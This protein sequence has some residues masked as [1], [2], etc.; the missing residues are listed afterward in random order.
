MFKEILRDEVFGI[1]ESFARQFQLIN[2]IQG[3]DHHLIIIRATGHQ[4]PAL[5]E[6]FQTIGLHLKGV[7]L[8][9]GKTL[10][11]HFKHRILLQGF[12]DDWKILLAIGDFLKQHLILD[13]YAIQHQITDSQGI[14]EPTAHGAAFQLFCVLDIVAILSALFVLNDKT[15][16]FLDGYTPFVE[17]SQSQGLPFTHVIFEPSP[18][19]LLERN[20]LGFIDGFHQ[21]YIL[22]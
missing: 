10:V 4:V 7:C 15:K 8:I 9:T 21:P 17:G 16:H 20:L 18:I 14:E 3:V 1:F 19:N 13:A 22:V 2:T 6:R 5:L 11:G 12:K